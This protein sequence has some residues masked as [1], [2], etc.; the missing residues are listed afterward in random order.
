MRTVLGNF[1]SRNTDPVVHGLMSPLTMAT[2]HIPVHLS[3][4]RAQ[5][6]PKQVWLTTIVPWTLQH[7]PCLITLGISVG[8]GHHHLFSPD[9]FTVHCLCPWTCIAW[10]EYIDSVWS[11]QFIH[12]SMNCAFNVRFF[13]VCNTTNVLTGLINLPGH[14]FWFKPDICTLCKF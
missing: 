10:L 14:P 13:M 4:I 9:H 12:L 1:P 11:P 8:D 5:Q 3:I 6:G 2:S 7:S